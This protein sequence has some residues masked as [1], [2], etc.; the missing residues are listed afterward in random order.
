VLALSVALAACDDDKTGNQQTAPPPAV[1]VV[2]VSL[3]PVSMATSFA[4]RIQAVNRVDLRARVEGFLQR[5]AVEEG[6]DVKEGDLL[7]AIEKAPYE[8]Q[9]NEANAQIARAEAASHL[10]RIELDRSRTLLQQKV[11]AQQRVDIAQASYD[12]TQADLASARAALDKAKLDLGYAEIRAPVAGRI[13]RLAVSVGNFV[14]PSSGPLAI[15]VSQDPMYV[16]FPVTQRELLNVRQRNMAS[17]KTA[18]ENAAAFKVRIRL[19]DGKPYSEVGA[20]N[21]VDV[22]VAG[23]TDT[24]I[25]RAIIPNPQRLLIDGQL[26]TAFIEE[27]EPQNLAVIPQQALQTDQ[28]GIYVLVVD[29]ESKAQSRRIQLGPS[30]DAGR[31]AVRSGLSEGDRIITEGVQRVR[32]G[33]AVAPA[34]AQVDP[35]PQGRG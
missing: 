21:F 27:G 8:V 9:V 6:T 18:A 26:I 4:G 17:G 15:L 29:G 7:L 10:A 33:Q 25:V 31:V 16:I 5:H 14:S 19:A 32:L 30:L 13:G 11:V 28:Q 12:S 23:G 22:Q 20:I 2:R 34:E 3:Q 1:T 35:V 24:V